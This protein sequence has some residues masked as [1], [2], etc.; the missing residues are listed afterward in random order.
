MRL[1][2]TLDIDFMGWRRPAVIASVVI[3]VLLVGS[4]I[5]RGFDF[6]LDFTGG[7]VIEVGYEE[8]TELAT[9]REALEGGGF[10]GAIVQYFGSRRDV[11]IRLP[12]QAAG[13]D[14]SA[15]LSDRVFRALSAASDGEV[16]LRRAEFVGPQVG[17]ELREDGGLAM[18]FALIGILIYV[19]VRFEWR[20]AVGAVIATI[21]DVVVTIGVFSVFQIEFNLAVL[22]A[23]LAVIGYS[24]NDTVVIFDRIRENFRRIRKGTVIEIVNRSINETLSRT[25]ITGGTT[26][27]V[28]LALYIFGGEVLSG[29]SLALIIGI[30]IGTYSSIYVATATVVWLGISKADLIPPPKEGAGADARP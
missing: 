18:L 11:V 30:L 3:S 13:Q 5:V 27:L 26:L 8:P 4:M 21:H 10:S 14:P 29:F 15:E 19:A 1:F 16:E 9:V 6:G 23:V 7:T 12:L 24:V 20:F 2:K 25:I 28:V 22:A 17:E